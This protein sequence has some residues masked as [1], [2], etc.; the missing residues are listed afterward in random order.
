ML[1]SGFRPLMLAKSLISLLALAAVAF[2]Q[3]PASLA[4]K[5]YHEH[6]LF[7]VSDAT[8]ADITQLK[9]DGTASYVRY[10]TGS[11]LNLQAEGAVFITT[12]PADTTWS[13]VQTGAATGQLTLNLFTTDA[14]VLPSRRLTF[15]SATD[16]TFTLAGG[17]GSGFFS[18]NDPATADAA[19]MSNVSLRGHVEPGRPLIA[20]FAVPG[21]ARHDILIRVVGPSLSQFGVT[22]T[23]AD[24]D[25]KLTPGAPDT[26]QAQYFPDIYYADWSAPSRQTGEPS[27]PQTN[28]TN[29]TDGFKRIFN[30]VGA[31]SLLDGSK[32]AAQVVNVG[33]G[34]YT[35]V[36][37]AAAGDAGGDALIEVYVIP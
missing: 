7:T 11:T 17:S 23:W 20:G 31:F 29:P 10:S 33:P 19:P 14:A 27:R 35:V 25:F 4:G 18:L 9:P 8:F 26:S 36:C 22:G 32:D 16:G 37:T 34:T 30:Y 3:A 2:A 1:P 15:T 12:P 13:Y 5:V 28:L 6:L 21:T 24:P